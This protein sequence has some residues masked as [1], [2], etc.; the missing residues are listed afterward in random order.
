MLPF[1][2]RPWAKTLARIVIF[3][4]IVAAG[5]AGYF[6]Y[7]NDELHISEMAILGLSLLTVLPPNIAIL[8]RKTHLEDSAIG[9]AHLGTH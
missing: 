9:S 1:D 3:L 2:N 8:L 4:S 6:C 7:V 5:F